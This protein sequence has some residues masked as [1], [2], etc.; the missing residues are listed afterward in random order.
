VN[1]GACLALEEMLTIL[2]HPDSIA[3]PSIE[4]PESLKVLFS[5]TVAGLTYDTCLW[6]YCLRLQFNTT[7][8]VDRSWKLHSFVMDPRRQ[9]HNSD[10]ITERYTGLTGT[11]LAFDDGAALMDDAI[12]GLAPSHYLVKYLTVSVGDEQQEI[13]VSGSGT[14]IHSQDLQGIPAPHGCAKFFYLRQFC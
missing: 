13:S 7:N 1:R 11:P 2:I 10:A 3:E 8:T 9:S 14:G 12:V 4:T 5:E 6:L